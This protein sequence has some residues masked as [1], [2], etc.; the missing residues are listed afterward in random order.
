M[1]TTENRR[2]IPC[3]CRFQSF[4]WGEGKMHLILISSK[5]YLHWIASI[6]ILNF[7][8][9]I[10]EFLQICNSFSIKLLIRFFCFHKVEPW[11]LLFTNW[12]DSTTRHSHVKSPSR[13][14]AYVCLSPVS[15]AQIH[16]FQTQVTYVFVPPA[17]P[18]CASVCLCVWTFLG[19]KLYSDLFLKWFITVGHLLLLLGDFIL[20]IVSAASDYLALL[21]VCDFGVC[22]CLIFY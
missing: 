1:R 21:S 9:Y 8:S 17:G 19:N 22:L 2:Q 15:R 3:V 5:N 4:C 12:S 10:L 20:Q 7:C 16:F 6:K 18:V 13:Q 14:C 11:T